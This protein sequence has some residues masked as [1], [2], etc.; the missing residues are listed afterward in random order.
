MIKISNQCFIVGSTLQLFS[1][2][3]I[4]H[5]RRC[6]PA[7]VSERVLYEKVFYLQVDFHANHTY[8]VDK[9]RS[10][11]RWT[12]VLLAAQSS[13][14]SDNRRDRVIILFLI[15]G[16]QQVG[17]GLTM[18]ARAWGRASRLW[19]RASGASRDWSGEEGEGGR[20]APRP[21]RIARRILSSALAGSLSVRRLGGIWGNAQ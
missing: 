20:G 3:V 8:L 9:K 10:G 7:L 11:Q 12:I 1:P 17:F 19:S 15:L 16:I 4:D 21:A 5:Y 14:N 18:A 6:F 13:V 2:M